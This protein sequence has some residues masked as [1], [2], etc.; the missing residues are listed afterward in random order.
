[1]GNWSNMRVQPQGFGELDVWL[2]VFGKRTM[3]QKK[4]MIKFHLDGVIVVL[5]TVVGT[6]K[7]GIN[8]NF[9]Y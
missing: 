4:K 7:L 1:M 8:S 5:T 9:N 2:N 6:H 3:L